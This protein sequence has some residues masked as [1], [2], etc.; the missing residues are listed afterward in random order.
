MLKDVVTG[1]GATISESSI[2]NASKSLNAIVS[3]RES[4][5]AHLGRHQSSI[6]HLNKSSDEDRTS[7]QAGNI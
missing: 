7:H 4:I 2:I 3:L 1:L 6:H 5:D